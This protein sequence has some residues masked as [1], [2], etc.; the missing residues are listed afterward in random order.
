M[1]ALCA[2]DHSRT[3]PH[4]GGAP[5]HH[6]ALNDG[7]AIFHNTLTG[8]PAKVTGI[9]DGEDHYDV[10]NYGQLQK[11]SRG[12]AMVA[13]LAAIPQVDEGKRFSIGAGAGYFNKEGSI[14]VG[15]SM[16]IAGNAIVKAGVSF[17]PSDMNSPA[18]NAGFAWSW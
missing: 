3:H 5:V 16:R 13:G 2:V 8:G 4:G 17:T 7:G 14:A 15:G 18:A 11:V 9:A 12:V 6:A 10:V 1:A